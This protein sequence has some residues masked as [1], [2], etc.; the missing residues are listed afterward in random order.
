MRNIVL[1]LIFVF[2]SCNQKNENVLT[3]QNTRVDKTLHDQKE[4]SKNK[5]FEIGQLYNES[6]VSL[7][8][9]YVNYN[10]GKY[11]FEK[12][13][14]DFLVDSTLTE[15]ERNNSL[16]NL[17]NASLSAKDK[18]IIS[19]RNFAVSNINNQGKL[20]EIFLKKERDERWKVIDI[21]DIGKAINGDINQ[22]EMEGNQYL[23]FSCYNN[24][25][26][27]YFGIVVN[28][29]NSLRKYEKVLKAY[30]FDLVNEKIIE[31]DLKKEKVECF[32]EIGD[33]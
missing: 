29:V 32:P 28:K 21:V 15:D 2:F 14:P 11:K 20:S 27:Q 33:E 7:G 4:Y 19:L 5:R 10:S 6:D 26:Y 13:Y 16:L 8:S 30:K 22:Y 23:S 9:I 1:I 24:K 25:G 18:N 17:E 31:V 3:K 12:E